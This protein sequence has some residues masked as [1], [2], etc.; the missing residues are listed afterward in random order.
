MCF[1]YDFYSERGYD[2]VRRFISEHRVLCDDLADIIVQH[3]LGRV[4]LDIDGE[5]VEKY[6]EDAGCKLPFSGRML[7]QY[8]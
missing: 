1:M 4:D 8:W 5:F 3:A 6:F 2:A 7:L